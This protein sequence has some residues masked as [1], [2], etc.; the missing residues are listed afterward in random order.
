MRH[1]VSQFGFKLQFCFLAS[2][3]IVKDT[4][5]LGVGGAGADI[6]AYMAIK[7]KCP[8]IALNTVSHSLSN[9]KYGQT[10]LLGPKSCQGLPAR[11]PARGRKAA[12]ETRQDIIALLDGIS[13]L[14]LV[15]GLGGG[16]GSGAVPAIARMAREQEIAVLA[17]VTLP[18]TLETN[19][20]SVAKVCLQELEEA[21]ATIVAFDH[22]SWPMVSGGAALSLNAVLEAARD[23]LVGMTVKQLRLGRGLF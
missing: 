9:R 6:A 7:L 11:T 1:V 10:L 18:F 12:E 13:Q 19:R 15:A 22:E 21:G 14:V 23:R 5:V 4:L 3:H 8:M 20:R 17:A 16:T 2:Y